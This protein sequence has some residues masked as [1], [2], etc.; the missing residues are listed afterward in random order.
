MHIWEDVHGHFL[1]MARRW[2]KDE[3]LQ[4]EFLCL[5]WAKWQRY[6]GLL[7]GLIGG[8]VRISILRGLRFV[9]GVRGRRAYRIPAY[10]LTALAPS[11]ARSREVAPDRAAE[12]K[13]EVALVMS[14]AENMLERGWADGKILSEKTGETAARLAVKRRTLAPAGRA[15]KHRCRK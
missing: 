5:C 10:K 14:Q 11:V 12:V 1:A 15:L 6:P 3:E 7:R 13:E 8:M 2:F 9:H 4:Q